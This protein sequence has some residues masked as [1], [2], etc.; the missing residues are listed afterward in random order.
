MALSARQST[1]R[2]LKRKIL[3]VRV[4]KEM[5]DKLKRQV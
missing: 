5:V 3:L 4:F 2:R 1:L